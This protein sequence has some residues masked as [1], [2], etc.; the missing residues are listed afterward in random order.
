[1]CGTAI[2][3]T[4]EQG[5]PIVG[6]TLLIMLNAHNDNVPFMLPELE[7][8]QQWHR[9]FDTIAPQVPDR[10]YKPGGSYP[11][12]GRSVAVFKVIPPVRERRRGFAGSVAAS[13][14]PEPAPV[15]G[16]APLALPAATEPA[17][18]GSES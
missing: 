18:M 11:L 6:D 7:P 8:D 3:E 9:V 1:L 17:T 13:P 2:E 10:A 15:P 4:G 12:Q 16:P 5:E 14:E